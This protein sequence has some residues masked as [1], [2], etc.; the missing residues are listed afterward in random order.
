MSLKGAAPSNPISLA[1]LSDGG[2]Y[3]ID[4][5]FDV[6][7]ELSVDGGQS[8]TDSF[9]DVFVEID[10]PGL[11]GTSLHNA[12]PIR[13]QSP[14][15]DGIPPLGA[16]FETPGDWPG[17]ELLAPAGEKTGYLVVKVVHTMPP[18]RPEW[19]VLECEC[20]ER[21]PGHTFTDDEDC[22]DCADLNCDGV[23]NFKDFAIMAL[24][25]LTSCP[26]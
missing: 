16:V 20:T 21:D 3:H 24:Q 1:S 12:S 9:F 23:V 2:L 4:S 17:V 15:I 26:D 25:W 22:S 11:V 19:E 10:L 5:F 14:G 8:L 6:F 13:L 7:T 18:A